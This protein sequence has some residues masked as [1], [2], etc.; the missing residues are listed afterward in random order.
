MRFQEPGPFE[1]PEKYWFGT[2]MDDLPVIMDTFVLFR[3]W[4]EKFEAVF[5][6]FLT[7]HPGKSCEVVLL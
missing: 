3:G 6:G 2:G 7:G 4:L 1:S 5:L